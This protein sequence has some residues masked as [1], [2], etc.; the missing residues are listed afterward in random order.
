MFL[1]YINWKGQAAYVHLCI[2]LY[3]KTFRRACMLFSGCGLY[4]AKNF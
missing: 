4:T 2:P 1:V 3:T